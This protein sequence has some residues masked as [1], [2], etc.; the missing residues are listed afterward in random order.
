MQDTVDKHDQIQQMDKIYQN[1]LLCIVAAAG[2]D[3]NAG[4]P[5]VSTQRD[6]RQS[7]IEL[8]DMKLSNTVADL[9][10]SLEGTFWR[11]RGW[12][13]QEN[14]LSARK[15]IFTPD[16]TYYHC[17]HGQCMEHTHSF[18]HENLV[19]SRD[20]SSLGLD[21]DNV[22]NW[23]VYK[24]VV[25]EYSSCELSF[26]ADMLNAFMGL[27]SFLSKELFM[28]WPFIIGIPLCSLEVG[29]L[30]QPAM[31]LRRRVTTKLP[32]WS[33][34]G[35][36]GLINYADENE[37]ERTIS[38]IKFSIDVGSGVMSAM[39]APLDHSALRQDW[40]R[41]VVGELNDV[42]YTRVDLPSTRWFSHP[43]P[44]LPEWPPRL[45][46]NVLLR[47]TA[48]IAKLNITGTHVELW[49][50]SCSEDEHDVCHLQVYDRER[51]RAGVVV[52][53]GATYEQTSFSQSTF[54][55]VKI[56]Q[57]TLTARDDPAWSEKSKSFAGQPR[58]P[59]INPRDPLDPSEE[60]FDQEVY[61]RNICWCM[62]NV[63]VVKFEGEIA[64]R[65]AVGRVHVDAFD[66]ADPEQ[67]TFC[68]G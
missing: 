23:R 66:G 53:D 59:A 2:R 42:H 37:F 8:D 52:M 44:A 65:I 58:K 21:I 54:T 46:S 39:D 9:T 35:W 34:V 28:G 63:L 4:L 38:R 12:C 43:I 3:A 45:S 57:S 49:Y 22:S 41:H 25:G 18:D 64:R 15:L 67:K 1:A 24:D 7:I 16:Q 55:F 62:Y 17:E 56:A 48:E 68:L 40:Q 29:L 61:D 13:F 14:L 32:S 31:R 10:T 19:S 11:S 33:W 26:E 27:S 30:W 5:G 47:C 6:V 60:E 50:Q 36:V 20:H 51:H